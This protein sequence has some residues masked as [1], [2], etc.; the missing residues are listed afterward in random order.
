R[1]GGGSAD[2]D[3]TN[4]MVA[5]L[6]EIA[7][8]QQRDKSGEDEDAHYRKKLLVSGVRHLVAAI[9]LEQPL[10]IVF[11]GLQ[12]TDKPTLDLLAELVKTADPLPVL[13]LLVSRPDERITGILE[14]KVRIELEGLSSEEQIRLVESRLGVKEGVRQVCAELMPR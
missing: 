5:R 14:N 2:A 7:S 12:W 9:A 3:V 8:N 11:E 4:P 1:A 13:V 6:A 10:V